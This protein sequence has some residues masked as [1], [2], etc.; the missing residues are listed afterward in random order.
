MS[1]IDF[2]AW[3]NVTVQV[4]LHCKLFFQAFFRTLV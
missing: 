2:A 1:G 4:K 3:L